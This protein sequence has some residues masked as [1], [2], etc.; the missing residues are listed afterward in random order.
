MKQGRLKEAF[1]G[2]DHFRDNNRD[3]LHQIRS[4]EK[5]LATECEIIYRMRRKADDI[6]IN[7]NR[8][9]HDYQHAL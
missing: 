7:F 8:L 6:Y 1:F 5:Y 2:T 4:K 9:Q 3:H